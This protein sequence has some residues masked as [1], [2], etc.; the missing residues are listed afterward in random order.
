L[1]AIVNFTLGAAS[2]RQR[3]QQRITAQNEPRHKICSP[4]SGQRRNCPLVLGFLSTLIIVVRSISLQSLQA[5]FHIVYKKPA[6]CGEL[7]TAHNT[8]NFASIG[9]RG[10]K[11]PE[12]IFAAHFLVST[13]Y[14]SNILRTIAPLSIFYSVYSGR[15]SFPAQLVLQL[16][17]NR[18]TNM[19]DR[20]IEFAGSI[21]LRSKWCCCLR[22][23]HISTSCKY[24]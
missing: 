13:H 4:H 1:D 16:Y 15:Q 7:L 19:H 2:A 18:V 17:G 23:P 21:V 12:K 6:V 10:S 20:I 24:V 22:H 11:V 14:P 3:T 9:I 5:A 8:L